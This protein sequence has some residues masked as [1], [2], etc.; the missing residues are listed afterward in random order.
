MR[1][2]PDERYTVNISFGADPDRLEDLVAAAFQEIE[3]IKTDGPREQ[4]MQRVRETQ[5]RERETSLR[6]NGYWAGQLSAYDRAGHDLADILGY[7]QRVEALT[8]DMVRDAARELLRMDNYVR[9]SL[10]PAPGVAGG[11]ADGDGR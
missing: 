8:T 1:Q 3:L 2:H 7:E 5:R 11:G 4:D 10:M 9:I 6:Q